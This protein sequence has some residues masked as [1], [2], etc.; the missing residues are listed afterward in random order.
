MN[1]VN[2]REQD[3]AA[4]RRSQWFVGGILVLILAPILAVLLLKL[5][6]GSEDQYGAAMA[7]LALSF[8]F[9]LLVLVFVAGALVLWNIFT[10]KIDLSQLL[11]DHQGYASM[12]R[13]QFLIF[14]FVV[15]FSYF[16]VV[17]R[18]GKL[19]SVPTEVLTLLGISATTYAVGKGIDQ[20]TAED[21]KKSDADKE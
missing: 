20:N 5:P 13:F 4:Q 14:T 2:N 12:A 7:V 8:G 16:F 9:T 6:G 10:N 11:C 1:T 21:D 15:A 3:L 18:D 17:A 19:P